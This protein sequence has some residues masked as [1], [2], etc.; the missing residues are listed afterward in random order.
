LYLGWVPTVGRDENFPQ[1]RK[2]NPLGTVKFTIRAEKCPNR[3]GVE[4]ILKHFQ[5]ELLGFDQLMT[6][7]RDLKALYLTAAYPPRLGPWLTEEQTKTL[8]AIPLLIVQDLLPSPISA[9]ARF[10]LPAA[11]FAEKDGVFVNHANLAQELRWAVR[12]IG[13][14]DGQ[15]FL[16]LLERRGLIQANVVRQELAREV[17]F[18]AALASPLGEYGV[19]LEPIR[20]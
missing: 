2:G 16:S 18:F 10:V 9:A 15:V 8:A 12:P 14:T 11:T 7:A 19:K 4:E 5:G 6:N 20:A 17:P 13:R 3:R 1:D